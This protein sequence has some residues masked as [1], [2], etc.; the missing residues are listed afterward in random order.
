MQ[1]D[2]QPDRSLRI[3]R[4]GHVLD[5]LDAEMSQQVHGEHLRA[6]R[7]GEV[8]IALQAA[9]VGD[10]EL[11]VTVHGGGAIQVA[12]FGQLPRIWLATFGQRPE[13]ALEV[14]QAA[15]GP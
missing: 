6:E 13:E 5:L 4:Q 9:E 12:D 3:A 7:L 11:A 2:V 8:G 10:A 15:V 14:A 1:F